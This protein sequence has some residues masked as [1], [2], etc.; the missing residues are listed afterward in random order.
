MV[1]VLALAGVPGFAGFFSKD[2][3]LEA[4]I[5]HAPVAGVALFAASTLT[6]YYVAR[7]TRLAFFGPP[8]E[9]YHAHESGATMLGPLVVLAIPAVGLG[10]L[11]GAMA[12][13]LGAESEP[14]ALAVSA[15]AVGLAV[16][17][18][19]GGWFVGRSPETDD[20]LAQRL[21]PIARALR[22]AYRWDAFVDRVVVRPTVT[23]SRALWAWGDRL[24]ADGAVEGLA[25]LAK[26]TG[27]GLARLQSGDAQSY[28]L[29][30]VVGITVML[31]ATA[32]LGR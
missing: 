23:L 8:A 9:H 6:A 5:G 29:A 17:G 1:G 3:V 19:V 32:V 24:V 28:A 12:G 22:A 10:W 13:T 7:S 25:S 30:I 26:A 31:V 4:V 18:G 21:G 14:L 15:V 11:G 2:A 27:T 16:V 20:A